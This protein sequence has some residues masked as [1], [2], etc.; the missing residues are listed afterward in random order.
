MQNPEHSGLL[1]KWVIELSKFDIDYKPRTAMKGQAE[2][3]FMAELT[4]RQDEPS[5]GTQ[6]AST[7]MITVEEPNP[8]QQPNWNLYIDGSACAKCNGTLPA[9]K[10]E[11]RQLKWRATRYNIQN[12]KLYR[13][14]FTH[15][16]L[17]YL[18]PEEGKDVLTM[19]HAGECG[20]Y[21]SARS[22]A[23]RTMRQGYFWP[24]LDDDARRVSRSCHKYQQYADLPHAPEKPL[25]IIIGPWIHSMWGLDLLGKFP[26]AK[27]QFKYIIVAIDYNTKWIEEEPLT[28][29]TIAK[30]THFL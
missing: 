17:R 25:S 20:N 9:D 10:V 12:G 21:S 5:M 30:V 16:N 11:A 15:P 23:N 26:T 27:G 3:D 6:E 8:Q 2:A 14:G 4:E 13:Q 24:T 28:A 1:S 22:L 18:T 7:E 19:I 29:I